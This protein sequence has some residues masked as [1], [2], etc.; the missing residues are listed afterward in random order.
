MSLS[1]LKNTIKKQLA[2]S[3]QA[4]QDDTARSRAIGEE[5]IAL[6]YAT[7]GANFIPWVQEEYRTHRG[8]KMHWKECFWED[9][10]AI[11][12]NPWF[13]QVL[14]QK[15]AQAGY[16]EAIIALSI[17]IVS[18]LRISVGFGFEQQSKMREL[19]GERIQPVLSHIPTVLTQRANYT[20]KDIDS[21]SSITIAGALLWFF[22]AGTRTARGY[23]QAPSTLRSKPANMI[24]A[25]E[26]GL[27]PPGILDVAIARMNASEL[28]TKPVRAGS[29]PGEEG[30]VV[31]R[32]IRMAKYLFQWQVKCPHCGSLEFLS[33][34]GNFIKAQIVEGEEAYLDALGY[35]LDWFYH[36]PEDK[37]SSAYIG[38]SNC[39][40]E[41]PRES[42]ASGQFV[43]SNTGVG[44]RD[45]IEQTKVNQKPVNDA[46]ALMLPRLASVL[47]NPEERIRRLTKTRNPID[48][49]QQGLGVSA[50]VS[51]GK[52]SVKHLVACTLIAH[53]ERE[54]DM[55][56]LG[57]DQ[58]RG[59]LY[60]VI[61]HWW[62]GDYSAKDDKYRHAFKSVIYHDRT[63]GFE[64]S[65]DDLV[66]RYHVDLIGVDNEPEYNAASGYA[67][68]HPPSGKMGAKGQVYL[69][70]QQQ[71]KGRQFDRT[72]RKTYSAL[73]GKR[74]KKEGNDVIVYNIDRTYFL[75]QVR[76]RIYQKLQAFPP[77]TNYD[78]ADNDNLLYHYTT[79]D[80]LDGKWV[81]PPGSPDHFFHAD[82]FL[83]SAALCSLYEPGRRGVYFG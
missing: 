14:F 33:P 45:L 61:A 20:R 54:P 1:S 24:V 50:S 55:V 18:K 36:N 34:Y 39:A 4:L 28:P 41:L 83:E 37:I 78:S 52:I 51:Q 57:A 16:T 8:E 25:D 56:V 70:D 3:P 43:C 74:A 42:I 63:S 71:L 7:S 68:A 30:G 60:V 72:I 53:P 40:Q 77:G 76:A 59:G 66:Q 64:D 10:L 69:F 12:A 23:T 38:C 21:K 44:L 27:Y 46:I 75:D 73:K 15:A 65:L 35:P 62:W 67:L 29:T 9:L 22:Y 82:S 47:F 48:E 32:E 26:W 2:N 49:L 19:V 6:W 80:R 81:E 31:D 13:A 5:A 17:F 11:A 79:S 58:W